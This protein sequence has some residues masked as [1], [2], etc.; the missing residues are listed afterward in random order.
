M[1]S[2]YALLE[3]DGDLSHNILKMRIYGGFHK[4]MK[5]S[6]C[7]T[8]YRVFYFPGEDELVEEIQKTIN[9]NCGQ[10]SERIATVRTISFPR[11]LP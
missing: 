1:S 9:S 3:S 8:A 10:H 5:C 2:P 4:S 6:T 7:D 11:P